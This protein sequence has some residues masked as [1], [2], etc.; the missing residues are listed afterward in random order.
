M[1]TLTNRN[2][3]SKINPSLTLTL[4]TT[5]TIIPI[6]ISPLTGQA[7]RW[8]AGFL[9]PSFSSI[10]LCV[11]SSSWKDMG[12]PSPAG[13]RESFL[14]AIYSLHLAIHKSFFLTH[15]PFHVLSNSWVESAHHALWW[16]PSLMS[17]LALSHG[18]TCHHVVINNW[19][20]LVD[21]PIGPL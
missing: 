11:S 20:L 4:T 6:L 7:C 14:L 13:S 1:G 8:S 3:N 5:S 17:P 12:W 10:C 21:V 18:W 9:D 19:H 15:K 2:P 16:H